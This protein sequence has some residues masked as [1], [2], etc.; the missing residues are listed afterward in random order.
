MSC[1]PDQTSQDDQ[2][3]QDYQDDQGDQDDQDD[4][5]FFGMHYTRILYIIRD[6]H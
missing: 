4:P 2:D 6:R 1:R 3:Y 5:D